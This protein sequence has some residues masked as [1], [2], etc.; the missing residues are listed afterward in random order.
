MVNL[1]D[2]PRGTLEMGED[3]EPIALPPLKPPTPPAIIRPFYNPPLQTQR[4]I[5]LH[6]HLKLLA[7]HLESLPTT[8]LD[9]GCGEGDFLSRIIPCNDEIPLTNLTGIDPSDVV[10]SKA[11]ADRFRPGGIH[12]NGEPWERW[13]PLEI[14][15]LQGR[16]ED[17]KQGKHNY[18]VV[19]S[20]EVVEHLDPGPLNMF[21]DIILGHI[22]PQIAIITTPNREFNAFFDYLENLQPHADRVPR[23]HWPGYP[24]PMRHDDHRFEW[25]RAEMRSW[26]TALATKWGYEVAFT[27]VGGY[28]TGL[29]MLGVK[30]DG[31]FLT[32]AAEAV[33]ALNGTNPDGDYKPTTFGRILNDSRITEDDHI[34]KKMFGDCTQFATFIK[35]SDD[36]GTKQ[37]SPFF[38]FS[39]PSVSTKPAMLKE[40]FKSTFPHKEYPFPPTLNLLKN[41][42]IETRLFKHLPSPLYIVWGSTPREIKEMEGGKTEN[43]YAHLAPMEM[44][45]SQR[46]LG[47]CDMRPWEV[48]ICEIIM[49]LR[50]WYKQ[51]FTSGRLG[52]G[53]YCHFREDIFMQAIKDGTFHPPY[54]SQFSHANFIPDGNLK[55]FRLEPKEDKID[56]ATFWCGE[57]PPTEPI[58]EGLIEVCWNGVYP[59]DYDNPKLLVMDKEYD[60]DGEDM[61][62]MRF[63]RP[64]VM[65]K[66]IPTAR[67][68]AEHM[69]E[70]YED[71]AST[72]P[73]M[74]DTYITCQEVITPIVEW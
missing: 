68:A 53:H 37:A 69:N 4:Q 19:I 48:D 39:P 38:S 62:H 17:L 28:D 73:W 61:V 8:L 10:A 57:E 25:T 42:L 2:A 33:R 3:L 6:E 40:V 35:K 15:L 52:V 31:H 50:E 27:G 56:E 60:D 43:M 11:M 23:H 20:T 64:P 55:Y 41:D 26:A 9:I 51:D 7:R 14:K 32:E 16:L 22:K 12:G 70:Q 63:H 13:Y 21:G 67:E 1:F 5:K 44:R 72:A 47:K 29:W 46:F 36:P 65:R 59:W 71:L 45:A 58:P 34:F 24:H 54:E 30:D 66:D 18:D 74:A 49:P